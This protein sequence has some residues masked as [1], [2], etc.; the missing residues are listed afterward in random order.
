GW[1]GEM[2]SPKSS[3]DYGAARRRLKSIAGPAEESALKN[4]GTYGG[5]A[6]TPP[7]RQAPGAVHRV[8]YERMVAD[9]EAEVRRSLGHSGSPFEEAC[10]S[11]WETRRAVRTATSG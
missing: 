4:A 3:E 6:Y 5:S 8:I 7:D 1:T 2:G 9:T 10:L 11:F